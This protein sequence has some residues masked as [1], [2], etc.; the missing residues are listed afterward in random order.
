[1]TKTTNFQAIPRPEHP[2]PMMQRQGWQNLNGQWDFMFDFSASGIDRKLFL[3]A[4]YTHKIL[5]PF[6]PESDLSGIGYKDFI[7]CC[8]Y[9]RTFEI[10][11]GQLAGYV[12]LHF[13]AV[14]YEAHIYINGQEAGSHKGGYASFCLDIT[15]FIKAG[16]N[17]LTVCV[18]DDVRSQKQPRGKQSS[19]YASHDCDYTRTTGIWQTVWLEFL[20]TAHIRSLRYY[21]NVS[22][23]SLTI[24]AQVAGSGTLTAKASFKGKECGISHVHCENGTAFLVLQLTETH[25][26]Q[27]GEGNLYDLTLTFGEDTVESYF[28]LREVRMDGYRFLLNGRPVFQRLILDQGFYPDGI[29][30][31]P[32]DASLE[33]DILLSMAAGFNGARLHQ[34]VFEPR[35][36]YYCDL[37][38][39]M[40]WGETGSWGIDISNYEAYG[41]FEPEWLEII[42]RDFNHPA[43]IGWCPFN[44]TWDMDGRRQNDCILE[45]IYRV[46]KLTDPT[47]PCIDTSGNYH[48]VTDIYDLHDYEQDPKIFRS[49]YDAF[50][51][52]EGPFVDNHPQRQH[53]TQGLPFFISE[54]GGIKWAPKRT[55]EAWGY[56]N[57]PESEEAFIERYRELTNAL[58][59]NPKMMGFC[60]TQL[61]DVEQE[62]NGIY[63]YDRTPKVD[64]SVFYEINTQ[65][66]A[67]ED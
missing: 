22:E 31:A 38:G 49:H 42:E 44:E 25:L 1:M 6:C 8:W 5:V 14:D 16:A 47:R 37:H 59:E 67:I 21:P 53:Y 12:R 50:G 63:Y 60:Y 27:V 10:T 51:K 33:K 17:E 32:A 11:E 35:F 55:D 45:Q 56:G 26:W 30:T 36:L 28:G 46:T 29:Y 4:D 13:G 19:L 20:P 52:G 23:S 57:A 39:Y 9:H 43:I 7:P 62:C 15:P 54:Y 40:V 48:V 18:Y 2:E 66:A 41:A 65:K 24:Q 3:Q 58:L 34:K 64:I 61:T